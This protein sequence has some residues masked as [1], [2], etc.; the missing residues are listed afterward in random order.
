MMFLVV[1]VTTCVLCANG[2]RPTKTYERAMTA[3][4]EAEEELHICRSRDSAERLKDAGCFEAAC[5]RHPYN[6]SWWKQL[7]ALRLM[8]SQL[9]AAER[10]FNSSAST[11]LEAQGFAGP[12]AKTD[13]LSPVSMLKLYRRR[14]PEGGYELAKAWFKSLVLSH[15]LT[16]AK[17]ILADFMDLLYPDDRTFQYRELGA[18]ADVAAIRAEGKTGSV[19]CSICLLVEEVPFAVEKWAN[20]MLSGVLLAPPKARQEA[21]EF[22]IKHCGHALPY[23]VSYTLRDM[24][25]FISMCAIKSGEIKSMIKADGPQALSRGYLALD[26]T[27]VHQLAALGMDYPLRHIVAAHPD[28]LAKTDN[29]G[30]TPLHYAAAHHQARTFALLASLGA[31]AG[32]KDAGGVTPVALACSNMRERFQEVAPPNACSGLAP[33]TERI[34]E[35]EDEEVDTSGGGYDGAVHQGEPACPLDVRAHDGL[36]HDTLVAEFLL[37]SRPVVLRSMPRKQQDLLSRKQLLKHGDVWARHEPV[38]R[39]EHHGLP[40]H[41]ANRSIAEHLK[42]SRAGD[43]FLSV[44]AHAKHPLYRSLRY[45]PDRLVPKADGY[46]SAKDSIPML[47]VA[48]PGAATTHSIAD[49]HVLYLVPHGRLVFH[50]HPPS[51]AYV[52]AF[53]AQG[54]TTDVGEVRCTL[55]GGDMLV[56]PSLWSRAFRS[57]SESAVVERRFYWK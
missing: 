13:G 36:S 23:T 54:N 20:R 35:D 12:L 45:I 29:F 47:M 19:K 21:K 25:Q 27:A 57:L 2:M 37:S 46:T 33:V 31:N 7:G 38:P 32:A 41:S 3:A 49:E 18:I 55:Q 8:S 22:M 44:E 39:A 14:E 4:V 26:R 43:S 16:H 10:A 6:A 11:I 51:T 34:V 24:V 17:K 48:G 9:I 40:A 50:L 1:M 52:S 30:R 5:R 15:H 28:V 53:R 42:N 56:V